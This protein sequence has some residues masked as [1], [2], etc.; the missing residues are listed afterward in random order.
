MKRILLL[1]WFG[2]F[3]FQAGAAA[4]N[5]RFVWVFGWGLGKDSD[6]TEISR[7]LETAGQHGLN[8]AVLSSGLDT[9]CQQS[10]DYF[11]RL[12]EVKQACETNH[13]ELIPAIFSI[14]YGGGLLSHNRNLA[15]GLPVEDAPFVVRDGQARLAD[16]DPAQMVNGGFEEYAGNRLKG[17]DFHDQPGEISYVDTEVRHSGKASLRLE[18]FTANPHG[19]GRVMQTIKLQPHRCYR[20]TVW[21][22]TDGLEPPNAF[23]MV[24]L[25]DNR[26]LAPREFRLPATGDW[27]KISM[28]F[29]SL[30][31]DRVRLYVGLWG[32][33]SGRVWLDD[34]S[35]EEVG[36]VNVLHRPGTPVTVRSGDGAVTYEEGKDYGPLGDANLHPWQD[37]GEAAPLKILPGGRIHEGAHGLGPEREAHHAGGDGCGGTG[38]GAPRRPSRIPWVPAGAVDGGVRPSGREA[39]GHLGHGELA[40]QDRTVP[41]KAPDDRCVMV[42]DPIGVGARSP[43]GADSSGVDVVLEA[44]GDAVERP[45]VMAAPDLPLGAA[46]LLARHLRRDGDEAVQPR[47]A[48]GRALQRHLRQGHRRDRARMHEPAAVQ[49]GQVERSAGVH[50]RFL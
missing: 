41:P 31:Y 45:E 44:V 27:R 9:L 10:P 32:G 17:F 22:K 21:V 20:A 43:G 34:W 47:T 46:G 50:A 25:A 33:K 30:T 42:R 3:V 24:A 37:E 26:S 39:A 15:E 40:D 16:N 35:V 8:G 13:L 4:Y 29:N 14:G 48:P 1:A 5:D 2:G 18:H 6:V 19:H 36:P 23:Q 12:G 49:Q 11:R 7:V 38:R 28:L